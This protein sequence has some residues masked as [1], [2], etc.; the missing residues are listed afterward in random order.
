MPCWR[1]ILSLTSGHPLPQK[2]TGKLLC[3]Q[4]SEAQAQQAYL[5]CWILKGFMFYFLCQH[6]VTLTICKLH[7]TLG[8]SYNFANELNKIIDENL[9][10]RPHFE[11]QEIV[12]ASEAFDVYFHDIIQCIQSLY[13]NPEFSSI[14]AFAPECH[15]LDADQTLWLYHNM[16]TGKWWWETQVSSFFNSLLS[17][18]W[19]IKRYHLEGSWGQMFGSNNYSHYH[20]LWQ[21]PT[22][23]FL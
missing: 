8:L 5:N 2:L 1:L 23:T 15:Y 9:P 4:R 7:N 21:D 14:L 6:S 20:L 17:S 13:D 18:S 16:D 3:G 19:L 22:Y 10:Y 11:C 12:V